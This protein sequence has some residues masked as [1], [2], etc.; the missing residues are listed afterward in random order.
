MGCES[1][2]EDTLGDLLRSGALPEASPR[3]PPP[4]GVRL[5]ISVEAGERLVAD[6][7]F[8]V[9]DLV[10]RE[11]FLLLGPTELPPLDMFRPV[12]PDVGNVEMKG[13]GFPGVTSW[14]QQHLKLLYEFINA[15][16]EVQA[17][18]L[19]MQDTMCPGETRQSIEQVARWLVDRK[20]PW[21]DDLNFHDVFRLL[22]LFCVNSYPCRA[23]GTTSG[24]LKWGTMINHSC[25]PNV[26]FH[27]VEVDG[28]F[29]G[30]YRAVRP[31]RKGDVLGSSYMK[32]AVQLASLVHRRRVLWCLKGFV[33]SCD[34]C[35]EEAADGDDCRLLLCSSC[36]KSN[37]SCTMRWQYH[38]C[39]G[40]HSFVGQTCGAI[41]E[42]ELVQSEFQ[43][44]A[45]VVCAF[46]R[47]FQ[48]FEEADQLTLDLRNRLAELP[49]DHFACRGLEALLLSMEG[50]FLASSKKLP[51][52]QPGEAKDW[53]RKVSAVVEWMQR[54][55][56]EPRGGLVLLL[57]FGGLA[58]S[59]RD[60]VQVVLAEDDAEWLRDLETWAKTMLVLDAAAASS[61]S[62]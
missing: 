25:L 62:H 41:A 22:R 13:E 7:D 16:D 38:P 20:L 14:D 9:G 36:R 17:E 53:L 19:R 32:P 24:L 2:S 18:A 52:L 46:F 59:I 60:L 56:K 50:E 44:S 51:Q 61:E 29:E 1:M 11:R 35:C 15:E 57:A 30:R 8:E 49:Q 5:E 6:A 54:V 3:G 39:I 40:S 34:R 26:T 31:I 4:T 27:S 28:E 43:L 45:E 58:P 21:L 47:H 33:C 12:P 10:L 42:H 55:R 37:N 48:S 23:A